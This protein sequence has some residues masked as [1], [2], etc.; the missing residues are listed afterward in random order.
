MAATP[1]DLRIERESYTVTYLEVIKLFSK[2]PDGLMCVVEGKD[3]AYYSP[4]LEQWLVHNNRKM[5]VFFFDASGRSSVLD[6]R[7][8]IER[9]RSLS[10]AKCMFFVDRDFDL[11]S[12]AEDRQDT[13]ITDGYSTEYYYFGRDFIYRVIESEVFENKISANER[14]IV[15][16][17]VDIY[18]ELEK[19]YLESALDFNSWVLAQRKKM[20]PRVSLRT[21]DKIKSVDCCIATRKCSLTITMSDLESLPMRDAHPTSDEI[22]TARDSLMKKDFS[23]AFRAKQHGFFVLAFINSL[24]SVINEKSTDLVLD[25]NVGVQCS[26]KKFLSDFSRFAVTPKSLVDFFDRYRDAKLAA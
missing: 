26:S 15:D 22:S 16:N 7:G 3:T 9:N 1:E 12:P 11:D 24:C 6:V 21:L 23:T 18:S 2:N 10:S 17:M 19:S 13:Y 4:R 8:A 5:D 14:E 25:K 20:P